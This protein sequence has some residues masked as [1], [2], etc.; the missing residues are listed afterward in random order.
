M[1]N[2]HTP[3]NLATVVLRRLCSHRHPPNVRRWAQALGSRG[4]NA[5]GSPPP[6]TTKESPKD[7]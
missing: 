7:S 3:R 1:P 6:P 5:S 4:E 2:D